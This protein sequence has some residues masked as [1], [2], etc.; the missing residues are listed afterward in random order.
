MIALSWSRIS[1]YQTCPLKFKLKYLDKEENFKI[2]NDNKPIHLVKGERIHKAL[3]DYANDV[4]DDPNTVKTN[5]S[6]PGVMNGK[7]LVDRYAAEYGHENIFAEMKLCVD[8]DW[9]PIEW[10]SRD[11]YLRAIV[12]FSAYADNKSLAV[13]WKTGKYRSY[14]PPD[15]FGQLE[16]TTAFM[17]ALKEV[18][19][20]QTEYDYVEHR[21]ST[22]KKY[23]ISHFD[24]IRSHFDGVH[25]QVNA[26]EDWLPKRN[27]FC[28]FCPATKSQC[29]FSKKED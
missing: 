6:E 20:V 12:D 13:D 7:L 1:D 21:K 9:Q 23:H 14:T 19:E 2:D 22:K 3:E 4:R 17:F 18:E 26:E 16:L 10:F 11:A 28:F 25:E 29:P 15:G 5:H 8:K 27:D 24:E